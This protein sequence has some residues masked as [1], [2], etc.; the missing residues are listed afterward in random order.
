MLQNYKGDTVTC[1]TRY[2]YRRER[3]REGL[4]DE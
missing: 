1:L 3:E 2:F 4:N